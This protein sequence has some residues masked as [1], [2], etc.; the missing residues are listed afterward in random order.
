[1]MY[2]L[3]RRDLFTSAYTDSGSSIGNLPASSCSSARPRAGPPVS[4]LIAAAVV[5]AAHVVLSHTLYGRWLFAI[6]AQ[7]ARGRGLGVA[8]ARVCSGPT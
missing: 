3:R 5:L 7:P 8:G 2:L 1:M 4:L 6:W